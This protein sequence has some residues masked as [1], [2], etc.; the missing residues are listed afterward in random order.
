MTPYAD[1]EDTRKVQTAVIGR[2]GS[3]MPVFLPFEPDE[4]DTFMRGRSREDFYCGTLLGGCGKKLTARRYTQK[5][6]HFAHRPPVHCRRTANGESSADHLYI[7]K[8][9]LD[10]LGRQ[11]GHPTA[12][13]T[14]PDL[15]DGP[16]GAIE[17]RFGKGRLIR[18]QMGRLS[19]RAWQADGDRLARQHPRGAHWAY[20]PDSGL[21]HNEI[22]ATGHAIRFSCRTEGGT[23]KVYVGT[24]LPGHAV[25]WATL[26]ECRLT[27]DGIVTPTLVA[28][29]SVPA[30]E[31]PA[32]VAFPLQGGAIAFTGAVEI[33]ARQADG[34]RLYE[35]DVQPEGSAVTRAR[36]ALPRQAPVPSA[37]LIHTLGGLAHLVPL[38]D[39][40][41]LIRAE[42][43]TPLPHG[44]DPRWPD[45]RPPAPPRPLMGE[46]E[47]VALFRKKLEQVHRLRG[48]IDWETLIGRADA[49]P[50]DFT[51]ADR[52]RILAAVDSPHTPGTPLLSAVV[53]LNRETPGPAPF[54]SDILARLGLGADLTDARVYHAW[55]K[56]IQHRDQIPEAPGPPAVGN[57]RQLHERKLVSALRRELMLVAKAGGRIKW[58]MLLQRQGVATTSVSFDA[59]VRMLAAVDGSYEPNG[60]L[61]SALVK[62]KGTNGPAPSFE[63]VLT[64]LG[65]RPDRKTPTVTAAWR[66]GRD[67]AYEAAGRSPD[68]IAERSRAA[69]VPDGM[70][71]ISRRAVRPVRQ[72]LVDAA[73]RQVCVGWHTL[74][75]A[76]G[77]EPGELSAEM[78]R[79]ILTAVDR[80]PHIPG[81]LL[82]ALVIGPGHTPVPYFD[83]ILR[84]LG[85]PYG[86]RPIELGLVRKTEQARAFAAYAPAKSTDPKGRP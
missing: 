83:D 54:F 77:T 45:L 21:A 23:R 59:Q 60:P 43:A 47:M 86:L 41:W 62:A 31:G 12:T 61:L 40:H 26:P 53:Q 42:A 1:E 19:L 37:H 11:C 64:E 34:T 29:K 48:R 52:V 32:P 73:R 16:G 22:E 28:R 30:P 35:A 15:G 3:D 58:S 57:E 74:A 24:Q 78:R 76:A 6:C 44:T 67:R 46:G 5:K 49:T 55:R 71:V 14:Y 2:A 51:P 70:G 25:E 84:A 9:I 50:G 38:A 4:F 81:V 20:G 66:I 56:A 7:G 27:E 39:A 8:A 18:V 79:A 72:A 69:R 82:S 65:W 75:A 36:I 68:H 80:Q 17:V 85:R 13:V 33:P 10:W 63:K